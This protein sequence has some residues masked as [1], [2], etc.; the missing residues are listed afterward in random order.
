M[1]GSRELEQGIAAHNARQ[2]DRAEK[3]YRRAAKEP[4][5][6]GDALHLLGLLYIDRARSQDALPILAKAV[7]QAPQILA[8]R[9]TKARC[10]YQLG[11]FRAA[12]STLLAVPPRVPINTETCQQLADGLTAVGLGIRDTEGPI[13]A[14][15]AFRAALDMV[16]GHPGLMRNLGLTLIAAGQAEEAIP[17]LGAARKASPQ[18]RE[19][20]LGLSG[21]LIEAGRDDEAEELLRAACLNFPTDVRFAGNLATALQ[22]QGRLEEAVTMSEHVL[23]SGDSSGRRLFNHANILYGLER[24]PAAVRAYDGALSGG[25][26]HEAVLFNR[27]KAR[28]TTDPASRDGWS[29][30][31]RRHLPPVPAGCPAALRPPAMLRP[32]Q[33]ICLL[34]EQGLG[35]QLFFLRWAPSLL[36]MGIEVAL[37]LD[38]KL[39]PLLQLSVDLPWFDNPRL[40]A[41]AGFS[42]LVWLGDLPILTRSERGEIAIPPPFPLKGQDGG[43]DQP[44][45]RGLTGCDRLI[46]LT[47]RAGQM[48]RNR[49]SKEVPFDSLLDILADTRGGI[50]CLQRGPNKVELDRLHERLGSRFVDCSAF[51]NNLAD[52][53]SLLSTLDL[54]VTV[55]NTNLHIAES[56]GRLRSLVLIPRPF[57]TWGAEGIESPWFP[58]SR[59]VRRAAGAGWDATMHSLAQAMRGDD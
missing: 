29:D 58:R 35:D 44:D 37:A 2:W 52:M 18:D 38:G 49:L 7:D 19:L 3:H 22:E 42:T 26:D 10:E 12:L 57:F 11:K 41:E 15:P 20:W 48:G 31:L 28:L 33:R 17:V 30:Y 47:W 25:F 6:R 4:A 56:L 21:A 5:L 59:V 34:A 46:G 27:G 54:Y 36:A 8:Y 23:A 51:N 55:S 24:W 39:K 45:L 40:A 13:A 43:N 14:L 16:P 50:V 1:A 9:I 32:G 53:A